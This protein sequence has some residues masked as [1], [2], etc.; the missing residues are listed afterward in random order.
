MYKGLVGIKNIIEG[1][2]TEAKGHHHLLKI[3]FI[4]IPSSDKEHEGKRL[5]YQF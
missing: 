4:H 1:L 3:S 5:F 2:S